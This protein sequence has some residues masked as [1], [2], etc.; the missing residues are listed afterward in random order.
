MAGRRR[1]RTLRDVNSIVKFPP[2]RTRLPSRLPR[3]AIPSSSGLGLPASVA[4]TTATSTTSAGIASPITVTKR[5]YKSIVVTSDD[6][7]CEVTVE[8]DLQLD[9]IDGNGNS[10]QIKIPEGVTKQEIP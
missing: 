7:S 5:W 8:C 10:L 9:C 3:S 1:R 6:G 4:P 2:T